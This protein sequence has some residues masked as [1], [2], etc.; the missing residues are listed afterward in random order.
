MLPRH[1]YLYV[2]A[3]ALSSFVFL[4]TTFPSH[5]RKHPG[6]LHVG[7]RVDTEASSTGSL[8]A[9]RLM[10]FTDT[11]FPTSPFLQGHDRGAEPVPA[12]SD[13]VANPVSTP[14]SSGS[15]LAP[16]PVPTQEHTITQSSPRRAP[17]SWMVTGFGSK[18]GPLGAPTATHL[19]NAWLQPLQ[20]WE[21][22]AARPL[23]E[24]KFGVLNASADVAAG[25]HIQAEVAAFDPPPEWLLPGLARFAAFPRTSLSPHVIPC[26]G[27]FPSYHKAR[28]RWAQDTG[29]RLLELVHPAPGSLL[30]WLS[31]YH[32][33]EWSLAVAMSVAEEGDVILS[34]GC[35]L[36]PAVN[37]T[38]AEMLQRVEAT[39]RAPC[40][41]VFQHDDSRKGRFQGDSMLIR[42]SPTARRVM[43][44]LLHPELWSPN[45]TYVARHAQTTNQFMAAEWWLRSALKASGKLS[46]VRAASPT[47]C[48]PT[49]SLLADPASERYRLA[50][51]QHTHYMCVSHWWMRMRL[52][53]VFDR[54]CLSSRAEG[55]DVVVQEAG[56]AVPS[57]TMVGHTKWNHR[58]CH[59]ASHADPMFRHNLLRYFG[60]Q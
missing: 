11:S 42:V 30:E 5:H 41:V 13:I 33:R 4:L 36:F 51:N 6:A 57:H 37:L 45:G 26:G 58:A 8:A 9:E 19:A 59:F 46:Q 35:D 12:V 10:M 52:P 18:K 56:M 22:D 2:G 16:A 1:L 38:P 44:E 29:T 60:C 15:I 17:V 23:H 7:L 27:I 50:L 24:R 32:F 28:E 39:K 31:I 55:D 47:V 43:Y 25:R 3:L 40:D 54:V 48:L 14:H 53:L 20:A 21:M 49:A 34:T